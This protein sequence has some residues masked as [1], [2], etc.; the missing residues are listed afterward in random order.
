MSDNLDRKVDYSIVVPLVGT[1]HINQYEGIDFFAPAGPRFDP[2]TSNYLE[3]GIYVANPSSTSGGTMVEHG[4]SLAAPQAAGIAAMYLSV[5]KFYT[6]PRRFVVDWLVDFSTKNEI[7]LIDSTDQNR[8]IYSNAPIIAARNSASYAEGV[9]PDSIATAF[10]AFGA[11]PTSVQ[12]QPELGPVIYTVPPATSIFYTSNGQVN[13]YVPPS[14]APGTYAVKM[15]TGTNFLRS[16][17]PIRVNQV[18]PG[19]YYGGN[20]VAAA[21]LYLVLKTTGQITDIIPFSTGGNN[22]NPATHSA[23]LVLYG[24]GFRFNNGNNSL[25]LVKGATIITNPT[26]PLQYVGPSSS[27][28]Q[29]QVNFGPLPDSMASDKGE[30]AIKLYVSCVAFPVGCVE[31]NT[32]KFIVK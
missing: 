13:F 15:Y 20:S 24:T 31:A 32:V 11:P 7:D 12:F 2:F 6:P 23:V 25:Q 3:Y 28:G 22:W 5:N 18:A 9:A 8:L 27:Q 21:H 16:S 4:S 29:D 1:V 19:L 17:G 26:V 14:L 10:S 30:W